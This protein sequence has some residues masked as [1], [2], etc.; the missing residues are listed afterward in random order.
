MAMPRTNAIQ[1][2]QAKKAITLYRLGATSRA[3]SERLRYSR[4]FVTD[5]MAVVPSQSR[6]DN[7]K[8]TNWRLLSVNK[9]T[10]KKLPDD[11]SCVRVFVFTRACA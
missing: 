11:E 1:P 7:G 2:K 6:E 8:D 10:L 3:T 9:A 5:E 4:M